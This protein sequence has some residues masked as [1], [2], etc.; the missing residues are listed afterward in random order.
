MARVDNM[1]HVIDCRTRSTIRV[2]KTRPS[3]YVKACN[4]AY[5]S[6]EV[7]H[8]VYFSPSRTY[9]QDIAVYIDSGE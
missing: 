7:F 6:C 5:L 3:V 8:S 9:D 2:R 1:G 4:S